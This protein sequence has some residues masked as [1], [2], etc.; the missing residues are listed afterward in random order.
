MANIFQIY[1]TFNIPQLNMPLWISATSIKFFLQ[2]ENNK[3]S[4]N[5]F[6]NDCLLR[7]SDHI[8][9][10]VSDSKLYS[11]PPDSYLHVSDTGEYLILCLLFRSYFTLCSVLPLFQ[12]KSVC[13]YY[14]CAVK[15]FL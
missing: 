3:F 8:S 6:F 9:P 12:H 4:Q 1:A 10:R 7:N 14:N 15:T 5:C 11:W 2:N 13:F